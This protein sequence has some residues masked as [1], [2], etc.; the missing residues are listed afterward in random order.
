MILGDS[1]LGEAL[2]LGPI[3][4]EPAPVAPAVPDGGEPAAPA[5][6]DHSSLS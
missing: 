4:F 3:E 5:G 6:G 2:V 1:R